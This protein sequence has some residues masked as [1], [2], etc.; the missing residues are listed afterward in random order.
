MVVV[1]VRRAA[2]MST[3]SVFSDACAGMGRSANEEARGGPC[4]GGG[5]PANEEVGSSQRVECWNYLH[6]ARPEDHP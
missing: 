1:L 3:W 2:L 5:R 6:L 4:A